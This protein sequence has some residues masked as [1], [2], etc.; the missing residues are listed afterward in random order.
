MKEN[1][2]A[3]VMLAA[4]SMLGWPGFILLFYG[5][6]AAAL[7]LL[8]ISLALW[9]C[10]HAIVMGENYKLAVLLTD[11]EHRAVSAAFRT[12]RYVKPNRA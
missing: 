6:Y 3:I 2:I 10:S 8:G 11:E 1:R 7:W 5:N 12:G 4:S 9:E